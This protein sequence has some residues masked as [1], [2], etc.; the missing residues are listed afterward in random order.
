[1]GY[2]IIVLNLISK[3]KNKTPISTFLKIYVMLSIACL[4][5]WI[6]CQQFGLIIQKALGM[7][8]AEM[9]GWFDGLIELPILLWLSILPCLII[10]IIASLISF[11]M[12]EK[13]T[14]IK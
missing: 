6:V 14:F 13:D 4:S 7:Q 11:V 8:N 9:Y 10:A 3:D 12:I 1:M 2:K 5:C